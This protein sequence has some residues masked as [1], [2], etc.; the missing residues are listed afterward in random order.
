M[1]WE[2][3]LPMLTI[4]HIFTRCDRFGLLSR[5]MTRV[6]NLRNWEQG[7]R[8]PEAP[9]RLGLVTP[10]QFLQEICSWAAPDA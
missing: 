2:E 10:R 3:T 1:P 4:R 5:S 7:R 9:A 6:E 8:L